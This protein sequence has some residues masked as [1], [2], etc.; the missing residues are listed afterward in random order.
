[1]RDEM[2][3]L[4]INPYTGNELRHDGD[5]LMDAVTEECFPIRNGIPVVLHQDAIVGLN[6]LYQ[7]RYDWLG[8]MYDFFLQ[9][10]GPFFGAKKLFG[11]IAEAIS[12]ETNDRVLETSVGTGLQIRNLAQHGKEARYFGLDISHG[13]LRKCQRNARKWGLDLGL[14]QGNAETIPF[15]SETFDV[16]FHIGGINFFN[17]KGDAIREMIRVAKPGAR[18]YVGD[19]T[20]KLLED[21]P[22]VYLGI[23]QKPDGGVY[24]PPLRFVPESMRNIATQEFWDGKMYLV[25]FQKPE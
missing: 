9:A 8:Y 18:I 5:S 21:H 1:M 22:L 10:A 19:E 25:S 14:V 15:A 7:K 17:N 13:M 20:E 2:F 6:R 3:P 11:E 12:V 4:L 24:E 23:Q 16:V